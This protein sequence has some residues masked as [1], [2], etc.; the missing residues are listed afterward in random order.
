MIAFSC[1]LGWFMAGVA[2]ANS[3]DQVPYGW[4]AALPGYLLAAFVLNF[5]PGSPDEAFWGCAL[6]A[7]AALYGLVAYL[8]TRIIGKQRSVS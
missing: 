3:N 2:L 4:V 6:I 5:L 7:N 1:L 8:V